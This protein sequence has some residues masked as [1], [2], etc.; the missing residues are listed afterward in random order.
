MKEL[1]KIFLKSTKNTEILAS[2]IAKHAEKKLFIGLYGDL[3]SGKTTFARFFINA[4]S[5]GNYNVKSPTFS[6]VNT[7]ELQDITIW[8]FDLYRLKVAEE[9]FHLDYDMALND[10]V[11]VEWPEIIKR[12]LPENRIEIIFS[13]DADLKRFANLR[14]LGNYKST[15]GCLFE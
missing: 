7:Y 3:G 6:M 5:N 15:I 4:F 10:I 13:E 2:R 8:H 11:I 9:I 1:N 14:F 12:Y